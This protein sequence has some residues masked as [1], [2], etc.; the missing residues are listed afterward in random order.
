[1]EAR[2]IIQEFQ[3]I[4]RR[5]AL[6]ELDAWINKARSSLV[7]SFANGR[8]MDKAAVAAAIAVPWSNGA[9]RGTDLQAEARQTPNVRPREYRSSS[10]GVIGL[11]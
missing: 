7:A 4:I 5:K 9:G 6:N 11:A 3:G 2:D 1:V 10:G 8:S